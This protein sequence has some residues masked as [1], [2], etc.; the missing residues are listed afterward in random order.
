[1]TLFDISKQLKNGEITSAELCTS[2]LAKTKELEPKL[3]A[4]L[5]LDE[6]QILAQADASD[7]R[8]AEGKSLSRFDGIPIALKD[9]ISTKDEQ[10]TCGSKIL[11]PYK[12]AY[13]ATDFPI[14][15]SSDLRCSM[16]CNIEGTAIRIPGSA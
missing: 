5:H 14:A 9:L 6:K 10:C 1:M 3:Q 16:R 13:D 12:S 8:R 7:K 2:Y 4:F 15:I 11:E